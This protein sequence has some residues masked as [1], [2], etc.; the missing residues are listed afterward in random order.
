MGYLKPRLSREAEHWHFVCL[1]SLFLAPCQSC[2]PLTAELNHFS[3]IFPAR[4][5]TPQVSGIC[6]YQNARAGVGNLTW[7]ARCW[8]VAQHPGCLDTEEC[9]FWHVWKAAHRCGSADTLWSQSSPEQV[10]P[11][12]G[13]WAAYFPSCS[14]VLLDVS[15]EHH[16]SRSSAWIF[17]TSVSQFSRSVVSDSLWPHEPHHAR[18]PCPSPT[19]RVY[20][21][22]CPSSPW[23]HPTISSSVI[24]VSSCPQSFPASDLF[25]WVSSSHQVDK[26]LE[27]QLQHQSFQWIL[28]I[29]F[30]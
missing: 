18:P 25:Q 1:V 13:P 7:S 20:P 4:G 16:R 19:P 10:L 24:S 27:F 23:C 28:R 26:V 2:C 5:Q 30:R 9:P 12:L 8:G 6:L 14:S 3:N 11:A 15:R 22:P 17:H 21:N 29:D